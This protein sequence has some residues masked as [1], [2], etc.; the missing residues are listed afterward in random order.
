M[1]VEPR[2]EAVDENHRADMRRGTGTR[3]ALPQG[4]LDRIQEDVQR[5][6]LDGRVTL[7]VIAQPLGEC[8]TML[9]HRIERLSVTQPGKA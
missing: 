7:Q 6:V 1:G 5:R 9:L 4:F 3:T 8:F 2:A